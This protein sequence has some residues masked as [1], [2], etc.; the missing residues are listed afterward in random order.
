MIDITRAAWLIRIYFYFN[1]TNT[2]A[3]ENDFRV[4]TAKESMKLDDKF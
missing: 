3:K 4:L 2:V 1:K